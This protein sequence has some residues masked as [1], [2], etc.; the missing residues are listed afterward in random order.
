MIRLRS[1]RQWS[2]TAQLVTSH[3]IILAIGGLVTT[4]VGSWIVSSAF[5][6]QADAAGVRELAAQARDRVI[7]SF[8]VLATIGFIGIMVTMFKV[9]RPLED[10]VRQRTDELVA[11]RERIAHTEHLASLG[12]LAAGVA[13]EINNPLGGILALTSLTLEDTPL[14]DPRREN[15]CEV[16]KQSERCRGIVKGLLEFSRQSQPGTDAVDVNEVLRQTLSLI[17]N[18]A[19]FHNIEV[20][21]EL[22]SA[23]PRVTVDRSQLQ[24]V[25]MNLLVNAAQATEHGRITV[26]ARYGEQVEIAIQDTGHGMSPE[27]R[28]RIFDPFFTTKESGKGTGLGLSIV[29]G[30]VTQHGGTIDVTSAPGAGS[31]FYVRFPAAAFATETA[32]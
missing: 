8:Y 31:T 24:Q 28:S 19:M 10:K 29:Y 26:R 3:L 11:M 9:T 7:L 23:L 13:H 22:D 25:V 27:V 20:V 32:A 12:M 30:I 15:L 17:R 6:A 4:L 18:Q 16:V 14:D 2:L 21:E 1:F 5:M